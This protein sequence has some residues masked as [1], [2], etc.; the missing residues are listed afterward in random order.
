M[1][2]VNIANQLDELKK[3]FNVKYP[4]LDGIRTNSEY[5]QA[6]IDHNEHLTEIEADSIIKRLNKFCSIA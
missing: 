4:P 1:A 3:Q 6:L 5:R 2:R